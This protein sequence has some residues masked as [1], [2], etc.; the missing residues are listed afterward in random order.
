MN[1]ELEE[2]RVRYERLKSLYEVGNII[3]STLDSQVALQ[4]IVE[5]AVQL[6]R[7]A[8]DSIVLINPNT[9]F[10]DILA[11]KGLPVVASPL[12]LRVG[13]GITGWVARTGR[14]ARCP[15]V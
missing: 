1:N 12:K 14:P 13:E 7:A 2:L 5:H 15:D 9:E 6:M 10:L 8:S 11:A 3:H 4:L